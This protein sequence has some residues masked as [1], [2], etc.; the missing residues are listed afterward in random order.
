[1]VGDLEWQAASDSDLDAW[2]DAL[3]EAEAV[4]RSGEQVGREEVEEL[5]ALS[6]VDAA[7]DTRLGWID[8]RVV[9]WGTVWSI[10]SA[11][12]RRVMLEGGVVPS[13]R[14]R[15]LGT[16]LVGWLVA[17]GV[18]VAAAAK[19]RAPGWLELAA[20]QGDPGR[21]ALFA[22]FGFAPLRYYLQMR[23]PLD[24]TAAAD[25]AADGL[26]VRPFAAEDDDRVRRAHNEAFRDHFASSE[27]D[28]ESWSRLVTGDRHF[29]ADCSFLVLDGDEVVGYA[30]NSIYP[31]EWEALGYSEGWTHQL[32]VRRAWRGR[33]VAKAL[34]AATADAFVG[35][36]LEYAT[37]DVDAE[38]PTG[39]L[40]L[41]EGAGYTRARTRVAWSRP[42]A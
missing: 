4:D 5:L 32:G 10:P 20:S 17:R 37:L 42:V 12:Q 25:L 15:G 1:M 19:S 2:A 11:D 26:V 41:Y 13:E 9:A 21:E 39:A 29:R 38:N 16:E 3:A 23:R 33:G 40:A 24:A 34:L 18:D 30:L 27:L 36:G 8:G 35:E 7:N 31:E 22:D 28:P 14:R 6:Y